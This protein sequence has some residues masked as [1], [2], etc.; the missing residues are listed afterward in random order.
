MLYEVITIG[1]QVLSLRYVDRWKP[2]YHDERQKLGFDTAGENRD[3]GNAEQQ[4]IGDQHQGDAAV[5]VV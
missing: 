4:Q 3:A 2:T 5:R 1:V